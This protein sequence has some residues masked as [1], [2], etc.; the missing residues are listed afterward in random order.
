MSKT[1]LPPEALEFFRAHGRRGATRQAAQ[2]TAA[3][4]KARAAKGGQAAAANRA[5]K[6]ATATKAKG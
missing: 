5:K 3:E 1:A 2:M 6:K 4:R